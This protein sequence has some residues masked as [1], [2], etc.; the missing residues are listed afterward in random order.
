MGGF[1]ME[2]L[3]LPTDLPENML[4]H[5]LPDFLNP[6]LQNQFTPET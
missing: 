6:L 5:A 4:T 2:V 1:A 3:P